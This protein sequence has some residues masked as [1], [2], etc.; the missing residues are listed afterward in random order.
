[1]P[2]RIGAFRNLPA[3]RAARGEVGPRE[4]VFDYVLSLGIFATAYLMR[5]W[6]EPVLPP[7]FPFLTFFPA[8]VIA[9]FMFGVWH[10]VLV[11]LLAGLTAWHS[12]IPPY[13]EFSIDKGTLIA[14]ALYVFVVATD[15][16]LLSLMM[17]AYRAELL[18]RRDV[19][20]MAGE[21]EVMTNELDHRLK[22]VFAT[23]NAIITLSQRHSTSSA[24]LA[25]KLKERLNAMGRSSLLLRRVGQAGDCAT[26]DAIIERALQPFGITDTGRIRRSGPRLIASGQSSVVLSLI[27]HELGTN[28]AKYG[29]LSNA[30]G[31][32]D[33]R[34][35]QRAANEA[36]AE[37]VLE[38]VWREHGGPPPATPDP[39]RKGFGSTLIPRVLA[40][41]NGEADIAF[42]QEGAVVT[43]T[44][45]LS[46]LAEAPTS[47]DD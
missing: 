35:Q 14:M 26:L 4:R 46:A 41:L 10:G 39:E 32:V 19:E 17:S 42:P 34:W 36:N 6:L 21:R 33:L 40:M 27:L 2:K 47:N 30:T 31:L 20:N 25:L 18:A 15:L 1:M 28:A 13:D 43:L 3:F 37:P 23:M 38:I 29:A 16:F 45:P 24:D 44:I 9:G 22:N 11:A 7:G 5:D 8:V 12:F